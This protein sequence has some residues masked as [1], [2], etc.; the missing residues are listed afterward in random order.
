MKK[1][2]RSTLLIG[3]LI[4]LLM[5]FPSMVLADSGPTIIQP[6]GGETLYIGEEYTLLYE[7][8]QTANFD[9]TLYSSVEGEFSINLGTATG[10]S[11][12]FTVPDIVSSTARIRISGIVG[13][14]TGAWGMIFP[15]FGSDSSDADFNIMHK[16]L[17]IQPIDPIIV[18][19][20]ATAPTNLEIASSEIGSVNLSW[21]DNASSEAGFKIYRRSASSLF[22]V[23]IDTVGANVT[24][25]SDNDAL[26]FGATYY[27]RVA[28][29]NIF[30]TST[31]TNEVFHTVPEL[32]VLP[33]PDPDPDPDPTPDPVTIRLQIGQMTHTVNGV[34]KNMDVAPVIIE[35]RTLLPVRYIAE[36]L[37]AG[38]GWVGG[39]ESKASVSL[40]GTYLEMWIGNQMARINGIPTPIDAYNSNV[41]PLTLP[42]GR[43]ML[44]L[45]FIAEALGCEVNWNAIDQSVEV[46]YP[47][48]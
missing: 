16:G 45:R 46:I 37:G 10:G 25:Y 19:P 12:T 26:V 24:T 13:S 28:A 23:E 7:G 27:Y 1:M 36:P 31:Y 44:P 40:G 35:G 6:N 41:A 18:I 48:P 39:T 20:F 32:V 8:Y 42:P 17:I 15:V 21:T 9:V 5:L 14:T 30:G 29:Y 33:E 2:V 22:W 34:V 43:T 47:A 11:F 4:G 3:F 38:I